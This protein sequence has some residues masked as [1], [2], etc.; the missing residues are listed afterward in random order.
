[1]VIPASDP[2]PGALPDLLSDPDPE[3]DL[4]GTVERT[5]PRAVLADWFDDDTAES[6]GDLVGE[7]VA[8]YEIDEDDQPIRPRSDELAEITIETVRRYLRHREA[9]PD[10]TDPRQA[11]TD[12]FSHPGT[13]LE[14]WQPF[15]TL[16]V[17]LSH[18]VRTS[19]QLA[20]I[21]LDAVQRYLRDYAEQSR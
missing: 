3:D 11:M 5:D 13:D 14:W 20:R 7:L 15:T 21:A 19:A 12:W 17:A 1:M 8:A 2:D 16:T 4:V 6:V 9:K 18:W 10:R